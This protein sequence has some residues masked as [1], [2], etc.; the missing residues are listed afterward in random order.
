M[1]KVKALGLLFR[2]QEMLVE[3]YYGKHSKGFGSYYRPLGG[4]IEVGE[5]SKETVVREFQEEL[6]VD[7]HVNQYITCLE[8]RFQIE[9]EW[10]HELIQLYTVSFC[11]AEYYERETYSF[12]E[13]DAVAKWIFVKDVVNG[14]K[15]C[16]P[17]GLGAVL[18]QLTK[19]DN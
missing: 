18:K 15:H 4:N 12:L 13:H 11:E 10:S 17:N 16:Y 8:N 7:V 1:I 3:S 14:D 19:Q 5:H 2:E 6:G 9:Q